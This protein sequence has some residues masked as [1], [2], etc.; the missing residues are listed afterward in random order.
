MA[1]IDVC[2]RIEGEK[3]S[4]RIMVGIEEEESTSHFARGGL[5]WYATTVGRV[6]KTKL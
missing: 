5:G 2:R 1:K 6:A 4:Q 3:I